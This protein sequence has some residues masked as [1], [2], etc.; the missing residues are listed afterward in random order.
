MFKFIRSR[1]RSTPRTVDFPTHIAYDS[2]AFIVV[3]NDDEQCPVYEIVRKAE[4]RVAWLEGIP[5]RLLYE[6]T[7]R[8]REEVPTESEVHSFLD[9]LTWLNSHALGVQ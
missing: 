6:Q 7:I 9:R 3:A 8:W 2:E 5:A 4:S 1:I